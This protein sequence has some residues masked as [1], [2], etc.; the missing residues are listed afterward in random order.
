M[1]NVVRKSDV[2]LGDQ[3][4][5]RVSELIESGRLPEGSRL[6]SVRDLARRVGVSVYTVT[7]AFER[8][9]AKGL[10]DARPG[11]GYFVAP[12]RSKQK[13]FEHGTKGACF[14]KQRPND[15][16]FII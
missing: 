7:S 6:P 3:L 2:P 1:F 12:L 11:A 15:T 5:E 10:I 9:S 4:V 16:Q 8:L 13:H 14:R